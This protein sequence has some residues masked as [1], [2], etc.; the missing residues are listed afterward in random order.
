MRLNT[1][2]VRVVGA[3]AIVLSG[4]AF[5]QRADV[6]ELRGPGSQIGVTI[7]DAGEGVAITDVRAATPAERAGFKAG[8]VVTSFDGEDVCEIGTS[9]FYFENCQVSVQVPVSPL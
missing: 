1:L 5:A 9:Y 4:N 8:D 6:L 7:R 2:T 3:A